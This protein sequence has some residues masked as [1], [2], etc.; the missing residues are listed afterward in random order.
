MVRFTVSACTWLI[1]VSALAADTKISADEPK[2]APPSTKPWFV[3]DEKL[4][5][6]FMDKLTQLAKDGKCLANERLVGKMHSGK[7]AKIALA[8]P[9]DQVLTSHEVYEAALPSVFIIGSVHKNQDKDEGKDDKDNGKD[10]KENGKGK[11]WKDG[12][13]ATAW[14]AAADGVLVTNWHV[15]EDLK[16]SEVFGAV[17]YQ[18]N[19]YPVI[20]F[21]G[22]DKVADVAIVKIA[23]TGLKPL[24]VADR[25]PQVGTWVGV[26]GHPGD[27][28]YVFT[29]G[30]VTRYSTNKNED[31]KHERWMG[32]T[33]EYAGGSS[34]SPVLDQHG[35]VVGMAAL[36]LTIDGSPGAATSTGRRSLLRE[37][38]QKA[39]PPHEKIEPKD[40]EQR[41]GAGSSVQMILK[42]AVPGPIILKSIGK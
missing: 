17:D 36:T 23:A 9:R 12:I 26:L 14:V 1:L 20:D 18:G 42:M 22:G 19:V 40:P 30:F 3:D 21:L 27:N 29:Q 10:A 38:P 32:L 39:P 5:T 28:Y 34:G 2:P 11:D 16:E 31:G 41:P 13:Y 4:F 33:A 7:K 25:Y 8:R 6:D 37:P 35:S 15:F 24:P